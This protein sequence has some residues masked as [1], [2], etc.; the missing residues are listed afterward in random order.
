MTTASV[1]FAI[2]FASAFALGI[3][4]T[5]W[6]APRLGAATAV[7]IEI[8]ILITASWFVARRALHQRAFTLPQLFAIGTIAFALTM[9]S[10]AALTNILRGQSVNQWATDLASPLGLLGVAG[11]V[12]FALM[13]AVA[14]KLAR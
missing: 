4:R 11:Q 9:V 5:L 3:A 2:T 12:A 10:E 7:F 14:T 8:P 1:Y 13:P 6:I